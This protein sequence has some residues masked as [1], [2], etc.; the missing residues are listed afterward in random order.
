MKRLFIGIKLFWFGFTHPNL[1]SEMMFVN[2][3]KILEHALMVATEG[4]PFTTHLFLDKKRIVSFWMYPGLN[5]NPVDRITELLGEIEALKEA[6]F[7][8][9]P[10]T[11]T[12]KQGK[13]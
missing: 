1:F 5:K 2:M 9:R 13:T 3:A 8:K 7:E 11:Y 4:M 12:N 10:V 6:A